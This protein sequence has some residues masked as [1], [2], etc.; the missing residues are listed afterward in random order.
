M[1][2]GALDNIIRLLADVAGAADTA[3]KAAVLADFG[4]LTADANTGIAKALQDLYSGD[5]EIDDLLRQIDAKDSELSGKTKAALRDPAFSGALKEKLPNLRFSDAFSDAVPAAGGPEH[6]DLAA[7]FKAHP[8]AEDEFINESIDIVK[9]ARAAKG[10][11]PL[12]EAALR[13]TLKTARKGDEP[14]KVAA[15]VFQNGGPNIY[16]NGN[17][18]ELKLG[19]F[20]AAA[21]GPATARRTSGPADEA[22]EAAE[23]STTVADDAAEAAEETADAA[24]DAAP[25]ADDAAEAAEEA[26]PIADDVADA[27]DDV[28]PEVTASTTPATGTAPAGSRI[29]PTDTDTASRIRFLAYAYRWWPDF[30]TFSRKIWKNIPNDYWIKH[31]I[32][33]LLKHV[34]D[35]LVEHNLIN[36]IREL[37]DEMQKVAY[38][39]HL[40]NISRDEAIAQMR[41]NVAALVDEH[42]GGIDDFSAKIDQALAELNDETEYVFGAD[43]GQL[44]FSTAQKESAIAVLEDLQTRINAFKDPNFFDEALENLADNSNYAKYSDPREKLVRLLSEE[45]NHIGHHMERAKLRHDNDYY[46]I[47]KTFRKLPKDVWLEH[48]EDLERHI[49]TGSYSKNAGPLPPRT[50]A[51]GNPLATRLDNTKENSENIVLSKVLNGAK[52]YANESGEF[53][54]QAMR[55]MADAYVTLFSL[56]RGVEGVEGFRIL[57]LMRGASDAKQY[58]EALIDHIAGSAQFQGNKAFEDYVQRLREIHQTINHNDLSGNQRYILNQFA[59][60]KYQ[61]QLFRRY[62]GENYIGA[63]ARNRYVIHPA[64]NSWKRMV[65]YL[66]G[67]NVKVASSVEDISQHHKIDIDWNH[68]HWFKWAAKEGVDRNF[69]WQRAP[70]IVKAPLRIIGLP[71]YPGYKVAALASRFEPVRNTMLTLTGGGFI[72]AMAEE[73]LE[74]KTGEWKIPF[75]NIDIDFGSRAAGLGLR[76][77]DITSM[78]YRWGWQGAGAFYN[79]TLGVNVPVHSDIFDVDPVIQV[80]R[81]FMADRG[82]GEEIGFRINRNDGGGNNRGGG[83]IRRTTAAAG[84]SG[85]V[86]LLYNEDGAPILYDSA[87]TLADKTEQLSFNPADLVGLKGTIG[88]FDNGDIY[89]GTNLH[90]AIMKAYEIADGDKP[91][92]NPVKNNFG[93]SWERLKS[94]GEITKHTSIDAAIHDIA[95]Q[96]TALTLALSKSVTFDKHGNIKSIKDINGK[97]IDDAQISEALQ[98]FYENAVYDIRSENLSLINALI[99]EERHALTLLQAGETEAIADQ[100]AAKGDKAAEERTKTIFKT[101]HETADL[102]RDA[103]KELI[104]RKAKLQIATALQDMPD[105][106]PE[107]KALKAQTRAKMLEFMALNQKHSQDNHS[108]PKHINKKYSYIPTLDFTHTAF[109]AEARNA[110]QHQIENGEEISNKDLK[111]LFYKAVVATGAKDDQGNVDTKLLETAKAALDAAAA[112]AKSEAEKAAKNK[113]GGSSPGGID[114]TTG[115]PY[116]QNASSNNDPDGA[117]GRLANDAG[118]WLLNGRTGQDIAT[119]TTSAA[120]ASW[121]FIKNIPNYKNGDVWTGVLAGGAAA[122]MLTPLIKGWLGPLG[123]IPVVSGLVIA[124][125]L[126]F[127]VGK[128]GHYMV[129]DGDGKHAPDALKNNAQGAGSP[130]PTP[131]P[132]PTPDPVPA[133]MPNPIPPSLMDPFNDHPPLLE[134][135]ADGDTSGLAETF[136]VS[137]ESESGEGSEGGVALQ[138]V[139]Y[140]DTGVVQTEN[141]QPKFMAVVDEEAAVQ[142]ENGGAFLPANLNTAADAKTLTFA[143]ADHLDIDEDLENMVLAQERIVEVDVPEAYVIS[144]MADRPT[145]NPNGRNI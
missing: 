138:A 87:T 97:K 3:K 95:L 121:N 130:A 114:P 131:A 23:E 107:E 54:S 47:Q 80:N 68:T 76:M 135:S 52:R 142:S 83:N 110:I 61:V 79:A 5:I 18:G 46:R 40:G 90:D 71:L 16:I 41:T 118:G 120:S 28:E 115:R 34:D 66:S 38:E 30:R 123:K 24:E 17:V 59:K 67:Q 112:K 139:N 137:D 9:T 29:M 36:P 42:A 127:G 103:F 75:T 126:F 113:G 101:R 10:L 2:L 88:Y 56:G 27:A 51:D 43:T 21:D 65:G 117:L 69:F 92:K 89:N 13:E 26:T 119:V 94:S 77:F 48:I 91:P 145:F 82:E 129:T 105:G 104:N 57:T 111:L 143:A 74:E 109:V 25:V 63:P 31:K 73:G 132:A 44:G 35:A 50:T 72:L 96:R 98:G 7:L 32:R 144:A 64:V 6:V 55:D 12:D 93:V 19:G 99:T 15:N 125:A 128:L 102:A 49:V 11:P 22:T 8:H 53:N 86:V 116:V 37:N 81:Q 45:F 141:I 124:A 85:P 78:P 39:L 140:Q 108:A 1:A 100:G 14:V 134:A 20:D 33:P 122:V 70:A 136:N 58:P 4:K 84:G 133:P 60:M 106:T 62:N